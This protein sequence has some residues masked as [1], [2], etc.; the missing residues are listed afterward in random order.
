MSPTTTRSS[1]VDAYILI[2]KSLKEI[3]WDIRCPANHPSGQVYTQTECLSH[4]EIKKQLGRDHPENIVKVSETIYWVIEA[5]RDRA[6]LNKAIKEAKGYAKAI[7]RSHQIKAL[8]I[9]GV[10]GNDADDFLIETRFYTD[11]RFHPI[12]INEK[13]ISWFPSPQIIQIVL[14]DGPK[15]ADVPIDEAFFLSTAENINEKLHHGAI[16]KNERARVMAAL[17]LAMVDDSSLNLDSKPSVFIRDINTR[18]QAE[19]QIKSKEEL[20]DF[21][22]LKLPESSDNHYKFKQALVETITELKKLNIRSAMNSGADVL[23]KFYEVFLKYGNGAK[24]I[25]IVL[26]PR[27]ITKFA[28]EVIGIGDEDICYDPTCGTGGFLVAAFD[29]IKRNCPKSAVRFS[30]GNLFGL[31]QAPEVVALAV[32]NMIF[33]DDGRDNIRE[34][35]CFQ[36][37]LRRVVRNGNITAE[38]ASTLIQSNQN[39]ENKYKPVVT[40]VLMNPPFPTKKGDTKEYRF[41]DC[42]LQEMVVGG[43]LFSVLPYPTMV[44]PN[45]YLDW[46]KNTLL[47]KHTLLAVI[48]FPEDLFYPIGTHTV[49]IFIRK[50]IPHPKEQNVLWIRAVNDG[51]LKS[52]GKRL[53]SDRAANDYAQIK[54]MV[55]GFLVSP[56]MPITAKDQFQK[57]CPIDFSDPLLELV[58]ENYLD[59]VHPMQ[60]EIRKGI[61][62]VIRDSVAFLIRSG[63]EDDYQIQ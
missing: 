33:R 35:D 55:R 19:L 28:V 40:R 51:L 3:G 26:T 62:Q 13:G 53:P 27:H 24:E 2:K 25:G 31:E 34:G 39:G 38:F 1:E 36:K 42:A 18:V 49:G 4:A 46:R 16:N 48:T 15:I 44:K 43:I 63:K 21:I 29:Y 37:R 12:T 14:E 32:V 60:E 45:K 23:G 54:D 8:F 61:E 22:R 52:K 7:N 58:P 17:L 47:K 50:G 6:E 20:Y 41:I 5:K 56:A 59:Q 10:A 30:K 9:T 57:A 11:G